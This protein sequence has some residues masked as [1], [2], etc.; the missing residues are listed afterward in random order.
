[1]FLNNN[2]FKKL[3]NGVYPNVKETTAF[4]QSFQKRRMER[5]IIKANYQF[6]FLVFALVL[7]KV[8]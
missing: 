6:G 4:W 5:L 8:L 1:M 2:H 3:V 7:E